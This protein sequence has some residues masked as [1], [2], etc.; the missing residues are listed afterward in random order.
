MNV[1]SK[2][3]TKL[4]KYKR[5]SYAIKIDRCPLTSLIGL[6][7]PLGR[8]L[9]HSYNAKYSPAVNKIDTPGTP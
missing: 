9:K 6:S 3:C 2:S 1:R 7:T 8:E 4:N 5:Q